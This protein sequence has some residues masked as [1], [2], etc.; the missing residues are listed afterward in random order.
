MN[1][2][3]IPWRATGIACREDETGKVGEVGKVYSLIF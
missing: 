1:A 3:V 2:F